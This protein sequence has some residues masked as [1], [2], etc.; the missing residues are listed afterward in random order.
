MVASHSRRHEI[1]RVSVV[2]VRPERKI[3]VTNQYQVLRA[4]ID[5]GLSQL[6]QA[7]APVEDAIE[8]V[9]WT[10]VALSLSSSN[11]KVD[12]C[13]RWDKQSDFNPDAASSH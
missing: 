5:L 1:E 8:Q 13:A 2:S 9:G 3:E 10:G 4:E 11:G 7:A 6:Q 12:D